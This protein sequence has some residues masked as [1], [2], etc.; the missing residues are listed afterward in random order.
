[1][2]KLFSL[3]LML[4]AFAFISSA[5]VNAQTPK[6]ILFAKG[7]SV[8]VVKGTTGGYGITYVVRAKSGQKLVLNLTPASS[9]G[10]KVETVGT[11]GEM[12]LLREQ[13]GGTFE[14]GLEESGDYTI[15]VGPLGRNPVSFTLTVKIK[16]LADI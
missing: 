14:V 9:V 4:A 8:A 11:Y 7:K 12:V 13:S 2:K 1:M 15:F 5:K 16:K 10:I 6:R 3:S